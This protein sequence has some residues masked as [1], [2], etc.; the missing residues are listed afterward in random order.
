METAGTEGQP[1]AA[2]PAAEGTVPC[3]IGTMDSDFRQEARG[4]AVGRG[5]GFFD[6]TNR[7]RNLEERDLVT[8]RVESG[9]ADSEDSLCYG[10]LLLWS[11]G[12]SLRGG[13]AWL[14]WTGGKPRYHPLNTKKLTCF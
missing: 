11:S 1:P 12:E 9:V 2:A 6:T 14:W 7:A 13:A 10:L 3:A 4:A 8:N 5:L